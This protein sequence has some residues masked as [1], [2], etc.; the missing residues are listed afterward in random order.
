LQVVSLNELAHAVPD[1]EVEGSTYVAEYVGEGGG[2]RRAMARRKRK[3]ELA[4]TVLK[5]CVLK[6]RKI[7]ERGL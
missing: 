2:V 3:V 7:M 4:R 6:K 5:E 1:A